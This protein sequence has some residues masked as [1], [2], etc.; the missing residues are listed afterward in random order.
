MTYKLGDTVQWRSQAGGYSRQKNGEIVEV[1]APGELPC[2][3]GPERR[4]FNKT[5]KIRTHESYVVMSDRI[6]Y[7]P[8][9]A[10]LEHKVL[11]NLMDEL[12]YN[13]G[14]LATKRLIAVHFGV[15]END[16]VRGIDR[17]FEI[18]HKGFSVELLVL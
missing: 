1:V 16:V 17:H 18:R 15:K 12:C 8:L 3:S 4:R 14:A 6:A 11:N 7:W 10:Y 5:K 9:V 2:F 13:P